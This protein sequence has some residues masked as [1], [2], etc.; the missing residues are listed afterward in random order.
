MRGPQSAPQEQ[1]SQL[2]EA[3]NVCKGI[4][5]DGVSLSIQEPINMNEQ[6]RSTCSNWNTFSQLQVLLT[7]GQAKVHQTCSGQA[8]QPAG[9]PLAE[10][11]P[12]EKCSAMQLLILWKALYCPTSRRSK[13]HKLQGE[14]PAFKAGGLTDLCSSRLGRRGAVVWAWACSLQQLQGGC[15]LAEEK[16]YKQC[17]AE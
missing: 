8:G 16:Y 10:S 12:P 4:G 13:G 9:Q 5:V 1:C 7:T 15:L 6:T 17:Q 11:E 3:T 2:D 14:F